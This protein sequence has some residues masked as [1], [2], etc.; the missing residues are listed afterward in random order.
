MK[1]AKKLFAALLA[2]I[3]VMA[4]V[5]VPAL[6]A[7]NGEITITNATKDATYKLYKVFD[8]TYVENSNPLQ[9]VYTYS[10]TGDFLTALKGN[11]SPFTLTETSTSGK[12]NVTLN[13]KF[14]STDNASEHEAT[15]SEIAAWLGS[16]SQKLSQ[17]GADV[18]ATSSTVKFTGLDYGYYYI[19][20]T[21][22]EGANVTITSAVPTADVIDKNT[23]PSPSEYGYKYI[24]DKDG[25]K[26]TGDSIVNY[27]D[28]VYYVLQVK[29]TNYVGDKMLTEYV[30][31][32]VLGEGLKDLRVTK[33]TVLDEDKNTTQ[34]LTLNTDYTVSTTNADNCTVEIT[35]PWVS[36][37][38]TADDPYTSLYN[39]TSTITIYVQA[40]VDT[41]ATIGKPGEGETSNLTNKGWFAW[42][43][44][45]DNITVPEDPTKT[46]VTST[47]Y[48]IGIYKTDA[49]GTAL[50]GAN[51]TIKG[52]DGKQIYVKSTNADGVY[53]FV[54]AV[55]ETET[56]PTGA[57]VTNTV[58]SPASGKIIIKGV[59]SDTYTLTETV[60]PTGYNLLTSPVTVES[61]EFSAS[62]TT[63][64]IYKDEKGNITDVET[65][66]TE[67]VTFDVNVAAVNVVNNVGTTLP[68]TGGIGTTIFY[69]LGGVLVVAAI[70]LLVTRK[71]MKEE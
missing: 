71:R 14:T 27:G 13:P 65:Q 11:N 67:T 59:A 3:M 60:A 40:T 17:V 30:A 63:T 29:A 34:T 44:E 43:D 62:T 10:G 16:Q 8:A 33:V 22:N 47:T 23:R 28:T 1:T 45:E 4:L 41:D 31:H 12:Y 57:S 53:E 2:V 48:A 9:V 21:V 32:D 37:T 46:T 20:S 19:T 69:V 38:G 42:K 15:G 55:G 61:T 66:N 68:E 5:T 24:V 18:K 56:A 52:S 49:K 36:G 50:S 64:T 70:V 26:I 51:F 58:V 6:A 25:N 7:G 35:I 54:A 39:A